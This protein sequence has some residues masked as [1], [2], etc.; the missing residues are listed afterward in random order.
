[1]LEAT[2]QLAPE[3][4]FVFLSTNKVYGDAPNR[5]RLRELPKRYDY[6]DPAFDAG[7]DESFSIDQSK[8]S[9]FGASKLAADILVQEYGRYFGLSTGVF[10][11]GC[12]TGRAHAG[13]ELHGFLSYLFKAAREGREYT[14]F[15]YK[16]KQVRDQLHAADVVRA[17]ECFAANPRPG[18]VYNLGGGKPNSISIL[19]CIDRIPQ[20]LGRQLRYSYVDQHRSGDHV[21]YYTD[22]SRFREDYPDWSVSRSLD[23]ILAEHAGVPEDA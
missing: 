23:S 4:V 5:I 15:G 9:L 19:E 18:A 10:R 8:H 6:D 20:L 7:I 16:G 11:A 1:V 22:L 12:L 17:F 2:R 13:S 21:C 14:I 3:A